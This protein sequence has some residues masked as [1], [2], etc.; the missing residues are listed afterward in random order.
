MNF[1][2]LFHG[3]LAVGIVSLIGLVLNLQVQQAITQTQ[4]TAL[5]SLVLTEFANIE[6]ASDFQ[7]IERKEADK[8]IDDI[9]MRCCSELRLGMVIY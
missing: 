8:K 1:D 5:H 3:V 4:Q 2:K 7:R 6:R 9:Y